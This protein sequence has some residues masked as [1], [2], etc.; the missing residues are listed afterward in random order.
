MDRRRFFP[1]SESLDARVLLSGVFNQNSALSM[2]ASA[3]SSEF[4][5]T[6]LQ[7]LKRIE[8]IPSY[9]NDLQPGRFLPADTIKNLQTDIAAVAANLETTRTNVLNP[10]PVPELSAFNEQIRKMLP[11]NSV[12]PK[13]AGEINQLFGAALAQAGATPQEQSNLQNDLSGIANADTSSP[14]PVYLTTNDYSILLQGIRILGRPIQTPDT[15]LLASG[16][17]IRLKQAGEGATSNPTPTF[18]GYYRVGGVIDPGTQV[19]IINLQGQVLGSGEVPVSGANQGKYRFTLSE[20]L[21]M[22]LNWMRVQAVDVEG[23]VSVV[24]PV[25]AVKLVPP[26]GHA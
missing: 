15:P 4:P 14:N 23:H 7:K 1:S 3:Q 19:Q 5:D 18:V 2:A 9:L 20:P 26:K 8:R 10:Q 16:S 24:S 17:G 12:S 6:Y 13:E 21:H 22:G 11:E 25:F